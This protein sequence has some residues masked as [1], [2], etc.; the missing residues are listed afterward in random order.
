MR[1]YACR[2]A[3]V[4]FLPYPETGE[5]AN[6]GV[7]LTCPETGY[8][9]FRLLEKEYRRI[10]HF[11]EEMDARVY[12]QAIHGFAGELNRL[13]FDLK[14]AGKNFT[15]PEEVRKLFDKL[16]HPRE[17]ILR[18][19]FPRA[20][21]ADEPEV[22]IEELFNHYV[23]REFVTQVYQERLLVAET[24]KLLGGLKLVHPFRAGKIGDDDYHARFEFIQF[25][26]EKPTRVIKPF[27]LAQDETNK[28]YQHADPWLAKMKRLRKRNVLPEKVLFAVQ[29]PDQN[30]EHRYKAFADIKDELKLIDGVSVVLKNDQQQI[31]RFANNIFH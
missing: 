12:K 13:R 29:A 9:D 15:N 10:T 20:I 23:H 2:Y 3:I 11:F 31:E 30:D 16:V 7:V 5:F 24:R 4:K 6:V 25:N 22:T 1:K 27:Y 8:F 19:D 18:F 26:D 28:I 17:T 21:L 14:E